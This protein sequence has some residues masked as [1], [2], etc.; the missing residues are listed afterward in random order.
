MRVRRTITIVYDTD[1]DRYSIT[2]VSTN[3]TADNLPGPGRIIGNIYGRL[4]GCLE[5]QLGRIAEKMGRGPRATAIRIQRRRDVITSATARKLLTIEAES[6]R[7]EKDCERM[8]KYA[9]SRIPSTRRQAL[10]RI[11]DFAV[12]DEHV[13]DLL[14]SMD[15]TRIIGRIHK[16]STVWFDSDGLLLNSSR[17]SLVSLAD[18]EIHGLA[19]KLEKLKFHDKGKDQVVYAV[20]ECLSD[21]SRSFLL[22]RYFAR[23]FMNVQEAREILLEHLLDDL[24]TRISENPGAFEWDMVDTLLGQ[25]ISEFILWYANRLPKTINSEAFQSH[26]AYYGTVH[27]ESILRAHQVSRLLLT[28]IARRTKTDNIYDIDLRRLQNMYTNPNLYPLLS[29]LACPPD[30]IMGQ[31]L[32]EWTGNQSSFNEVPYVIPPVKLETFCCQLAFYTDHDN[33]AFSGRARHDVKILLTMDKYCRAAILKSLSETRFARSSECVSL[34]KET[35]EVPFL[36]GHNAEGE[37]LYLANDRFNYRNTTISERE[38]SEISRSQ[39]EIRYEVYVLRYALEMYPS[40]MDNGR[41]HF[42]ATGPYAWSPLHPH[43]YGLEYVPFTKWER[44][45]EGYL[46]VN[47]REALERRR[48]LI[49]ME[50]RW[51]EM[52]TGTRKTQD[53]NE[54]GS[55]DESELEDEDEGESKGESES[56]DE[57]RDE[58]KVESKSLD[59]D[60]DSEN[61]DESGDEDKGESESDSEQRQA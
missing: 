8:L 17:K 23:I 60:S 31:I 12:S 5:V 27:F 33:S 24:L 50:L 30:L 20:K 55:E 14:N 36:A 21:S 10:D 47:I 34:V 43:E 44:E 35:E 2:S 16:H 39:R 61:E 9:T 38:W 42:D 25:L 18:T 41:K 28:G 7:L 49:V 22:L 1:S 3:A 57:S 58:D 32:Y 48:R 26:L 19:R 15:A 37:A 51:S 4:G 56:E 13:R 46:G 40:I 54:D 29:R 53:K 11:T 45:S 59:S 52:R 6:E